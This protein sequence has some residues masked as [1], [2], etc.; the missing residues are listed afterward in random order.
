MTNFDM[1]LKIIENSKG[2]T[3]SQLMASKA[4]YI[5]HCMTVNRTWLIIAVA[6]IT[7]LVVLCIVSAKS[8]GDFNDA[9]PPLVATTCIVGFICLIII[10]AA[11][12]TNAGWVSAPDIHYANHILSMASNCLY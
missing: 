2:I 7:V 8:K 10:I 9:L 5:T 12:S 11:A 1:A 4:A 3:E 6:V